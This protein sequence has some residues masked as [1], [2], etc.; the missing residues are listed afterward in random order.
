MPTGLT[1]EDAEF[2][3]LRFVDARGRRLLTLPVIVDVA[4]DVQ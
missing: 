1:L 3:A 2:P 4:N